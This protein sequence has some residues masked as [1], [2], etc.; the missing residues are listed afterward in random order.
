MKNKNLFSNWQLKLGAAALAVLVWLMIMSFSDP[1]VTQTISNVPI[2]IINDDVFAEAGK[3]YTIDSRLST[4]VKVIGS[5]SIVKNL[6][7]ADF[8]ATADFSRIYDVTGQVPITLS[9]SARN[10]SSLTYTPLTAS[11]KVNVEDVLS[12]DFPVQVETTGNV[13]EGYL[14]GGL[15]SDPVYITVEAPESVI[16]RISKAS[17]TVDL[18]GLSENASFTVTPHYYSAAGTELTFE[19]V[20]DTVF[21]AEEV[22]VD[23]EIRTMKTVPVVIAVGGQDAVASGYRYTGAEQSLTTIQVSGLRSRLA[24]LNSISIPD[25]VLSVAGASEDVAYEIDLTEYLPEGISLL[26]GE[27]KMMKVTLQVAPLIVKT[28]EIDTINLIGNNEDYDYLFL[29][30]PMQVQLRALEEDFKGITDEHIAATLDV[31]GYGPGQF[32]LPVDIELDSVFELFVTP[33]VKL[34]IEDRKQPETTA[35]PEDGE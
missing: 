4:S 19:N 25:T 29:N 17:V 2:T 23:V 22:R 12:R 13:A 26:L 24:E 20:K 32:T 1:T 28:Y 34:S 7:A 31:T 10:A 6:S 18:N 5:N 14:L 16:E 30:M 35:A 27:E 21:S 3:S 11:L 8:T 9:C 15:A 33:H